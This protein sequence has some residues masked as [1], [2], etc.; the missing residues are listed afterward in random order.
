MN[1]KNIITLV[2]LVLIV[3]IVGVVLTR[4]QIGP[5]AGLALFNRPTPTL[6]RPENLAQA[7]AFYEQGQL[8]QAFDAYSVAIDARQGVAEAYAG[9]GDIYTQWRR[10]REAA[11]DYSA[12]LEVQRDPIVLGKRCNAYRLLA[13]FDLALQDCQEAIQLDPEYIDAYIA[14]AVLHLEQ[15]Q[16]EAAKQV[17]EQAMTIDPTVARLHQALGQIEIS[18]GHTDAGIAALDEAIRLDPKQPQFYWDRGFAYYTLG[19]LKESS[20]DM[21]RV[22]QN[23]DPE[24]DGELI[25]QAGSLLASLKGALNP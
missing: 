5:S 7:D 13:K 22:I 6:Q 24:K 9:R 16:A 23:G 14:Q 19:K 12:S 3:T 11:N 21:E 2:V 15:G 4:L 8:Q 18:Q 17:I 10:F 1:K 25:Y 20:E